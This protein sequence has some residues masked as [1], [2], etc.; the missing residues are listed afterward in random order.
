[1]VESGT[2]GAASEGAS[3]LR[4]NTPMGVNQQVFASRPERDNF[5][6]LSRQWG[7]AYR[8]YHN[9]PFLSVFN[10]KNL[11]DIT[12][13]YTW[14]S[15]LS[16]QGKGLNI[17]IGD[18][19]YAR[20]KKTS[21]DY[22]LC[23]QS[24]TPLVCIDFDGLRDAFNVGVEY[25]S[26]GPPDPWRDKIMSLKLKVAHGST[27]PYFV[28]GYEHF[29]DVSKEVQLTMVDGIIGE[30]LSRKAFNEKVS[31]GFNPEEVGLTQEQFDALSRADQ[32]EVIDD[33]ALGAEVDT[34]LMHNPISTKLA[35]V[36]RTVPLVAAITYLTYPDLDGAKTLAERR[37]M[38]DNVISHGCRCT[39]HLADETT[40]GDADR[41]KEVCDEVIATVWLPNFKAPQGGSML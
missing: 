5:Y 26:D 23:D 16:T 25:H 4:E 12:R 32:G 36:E 2:L 33:W 8:L 35:E 28:V 14:Q 41:W 18:I 21:I 34:E 10:T 27:F 30:V 3:L 37:K 24:D 17:H 13:F 1:M 9:L 7:S 39:L 38:F 29:K 31:M 40:D 6:K 22:T 19:D 20:L 11:V 15:Y